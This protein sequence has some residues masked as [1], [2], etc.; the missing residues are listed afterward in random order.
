M[1]ELNKHRNYVKVGEVE[2]RVGWR[3]DRDSMLA[4][5]GD[6]AAWNELND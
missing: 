3:I 1:A 5:F 2:Q 6:L 4:K